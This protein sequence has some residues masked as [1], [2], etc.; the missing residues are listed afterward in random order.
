MRITL[1]NS[2]LVS[3]QQGGGHWSWFLQY[4]LGLRALGHDVFWLELMQS[5]GERGHDMQLVR[6]FFARLAIYNLD[7][8]CALLLFNEKLDFQ[9]FDKCEAFGRDQRDVREIIRSTDL[10]LN[11]CSAVRQPLLSMFNYRALLDFDPGHLQ[12]SALMCNLNIHDHHVCMTLGW[13][14]NVSG[15]EVPKLGI[16]WRTFDPCIY[17]PMWRAAGDPGVHAPFT[18]ITQWTWEELPWNGGLVS[19]SKRAAYL[20]YREIP[21]L[22]GRP[23]E[24]AANIGNDDPAGDRDHMRE[25]GWHLAEPHDVVGTP[26]QYQEYIRASRAEFMCPK[27]IHLVMRT[28]WFSDRSIA[29]LAS[30]RPV[31]A[32]DTGFSERLPTGAG[33]VAFRNAEEALAGIAEIDGNYERHRRAARDLA[34]SVFDSRKCLTE[35]LSACGA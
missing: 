3:Y 31:L 5:T 22:A 24:L 20:K 13:R 25:G 34:E 33:L 32:E 10:L 17:L 16:R 23:F 21:R 35:M 15:S 27:P 7:K 30:G 6:D 26:A 14:I 29:Y 2:S 18:S 4:P 19:V 28:G 1:G 9:P 8:N 11:F 12:V